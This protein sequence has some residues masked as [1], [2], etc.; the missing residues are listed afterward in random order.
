MCRSLNQAAMGSS[1]LHDHADYSRGFLPNRSFQDLSCMPMLKCKPVNPSHATIQTLLRDEFARSR[2][3][4]LNVGGGKALKKYS[5]SIK[6]H[7]TG[8]LAH[9]LPGTT[10]LQSSHST[11]QEDLHIICMKLQRFNY[12]PHAERLTHHQHILSPRSK[13]GCAVEQTSMRMP[14]HC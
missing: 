6:F 14:E 7:N 5:T 13:G 4:D 3:S 10:A 9:N 8:R 2:S 1:K 12:A 11:K